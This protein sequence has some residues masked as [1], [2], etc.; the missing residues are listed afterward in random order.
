MPFEGKKI[1]FETS[2]INH[3]FWE[4]LDWIFPPHCGGCNELGQRWCSDCQSN[5]ETINFP[6]CNKCGEPVNQKN[7]IHKKCS[8]DLESISFIR[9]FGY[10]RPPLSNAIQKLK[11]QNDIGIAESL[12]G[13]ITELYKEIN[14]ETDFIIPVPLSRER[15]QQRG[16]NQAKL[17]AK[18]FSLIINRP[19]LSNVLVRI[20]NTKSQVGLS[21]EE[22]KNNVKQA[23]LVKDDIIMGKRIVLVDDVSTTGATLEACAKALKKAGATSI[24]GLTLAKAVHTKN[25]FSDQIQFK[26]SVQ[27]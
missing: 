20:S 16:F 8:L 23:F 10:Y 21:R 12:A 5:T 13:Y 6:I 26:T 3:L 18:P 25:G 9:S 22:R 1:Q 15:M 7:F 27:I 14:W 24:V 19:L 2:N 11:Y 4:S 17:I